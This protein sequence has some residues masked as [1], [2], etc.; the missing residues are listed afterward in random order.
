M[1]KKYLLIAFLGPD[2]AGKTS[3]INILKKKL[4]HKNITF[5]NYH[6]VPA[7]FKKKNVVIVKNP[8][9]KK[10]RSK[11]LS[12]CKLIFMMIK[13]H[14]FILIDRLFSKEIIIF[15]RYAHDIL[16]DPIRYRF[17]LQ[18]KF[19]KIILNLFPQPDLWIIVVN[20]PSVIWKRKKEVKY[21][22][23]KKQ[24]I[25]YQ[26]FKKKNTNSIFCKNYDDLEKIF[27]LLTL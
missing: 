12:F 24:I 25:S 5:T 15:D 26:L 18:Q 9:S 14:F 22:I 23:L 19:T 7:I 16:I 4:I 3:Y 17:N 13:C 2:G 11:F 6:F 27:K 10:K 21:Q 1:T 8:H 20:K